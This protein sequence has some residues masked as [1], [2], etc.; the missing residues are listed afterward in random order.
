MVISI[1]DAVRHVVNSR[2]VDSIDSNK[3]EVSITI[4]ESLFDEINK[5]LDF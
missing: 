4:D 2:I 1:R 5:V 3:R